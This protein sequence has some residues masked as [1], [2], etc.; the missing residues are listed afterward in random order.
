M[1]NVAAVDAS[2]KE[3][4]V[5]HQDLVLA[6]KRCKKKKKKAEDGASKKASTNNKQQKEAVRKGEQ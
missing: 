4:K 2:K 6:E 3:S 5:L 1:A